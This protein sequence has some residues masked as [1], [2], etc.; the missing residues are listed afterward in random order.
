MTEKISPEVLWPW[1]TRPVR[2]AITASIVIPVA[3]AAYHEREKTREISMA[4][5]AYVQFFPDAPSNAREASLI[6]QG[7]IEVRPFPGNPN[8]LILAQ[9]PGLVCSSVLGHLSA[10]G[11][12]PI[13]A[14]GHALFSSEL[15]VACRGDERVRHLIYR[16]ASKS[17]P[18]AQPSALPALPD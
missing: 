7:G 14:D 17:M 10:Y 15:K 5:V 9:N 1:L 2:A 3:I 18:S 4:A 11:M 6:N 16:N 8:I 12:K 13:G